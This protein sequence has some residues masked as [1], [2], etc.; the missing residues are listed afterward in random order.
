[1][2]ALAIVVAAHDQIFPTNWSL[3]HESRIP[4]GVGGKAESLGFLLQPCATQCVVVK[5][6][7]TCCNLRIGRVRLNSKSPPGLRNSP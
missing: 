6:G 3:T 4:E 1:M 2:E 7:E 5:P